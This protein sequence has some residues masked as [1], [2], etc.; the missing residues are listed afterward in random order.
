MQSEVTEALS[1][2]FYQRRGVKS[3][4]FIVY[5]SS[6]F[7]I[8]GLFCSV[9]VCLSVVYFDTRQLSGAF[10]YTVPVHVTLCKDLKRKLKSPYI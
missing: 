2:L 6:S 1:L 9:S 8:D 7:L 5:R 10:S 4:K 3:Q